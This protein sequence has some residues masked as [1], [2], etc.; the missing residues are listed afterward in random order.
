MKALHLDDNWVAFSAAMEEQFTDRQETGKD[1]EKILCKPGPRD[2]DGGPQTTSPWFYF[3]ERMCKR[4]S[5]LIILL[6]EERRYTRITLGFRSQGVEQFVRGD[7]GMF[8]R[9]TMFRGE[10]N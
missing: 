10:W 4:E 9:G 2:G 1:H 8:V 7:R 3:E 6:R 5:C